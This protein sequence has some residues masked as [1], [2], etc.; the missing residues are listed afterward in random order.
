MVPL[1]RAIFFLHDTSAPF[2]LTCSH[3]GWLLCSCGRIRTWWQKAATKHNPIPWNGGKY[4][5]T[6]GLA[7]EVFCVPKMDLISPNNYAS[8]LIQQTLILFQTC[9][10]GNPVLRAGQGF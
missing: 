1:T 6:S 9:T 3:W 5:S 4:K 2:F 7:W 8:N 10:T